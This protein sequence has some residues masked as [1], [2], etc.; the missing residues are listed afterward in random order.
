MDPI[1]PERRICG[2][3]EGGTMRRLLLALA[4]L[5]ALALVPAAV[6]DG[7]GPSPGLMYGWTGVTGPGQPRYVT[8]PTARS[9]VLAEV[10]RANG[11][12]IQFRVLKGNWGIP[13]VANDGSTG[14]LT[15]D[16]KTLVVADWVPPQNSPLRT[17][18]RFQLVH[19]RTLA[20]FKT[21]TLTGDW[22]Y[23]ALSPNGQTLYLIQHM[24]VQDTLKYQVRAYDLNGF[25]LRPRVIADRRQTGW[26]MRGYPMRRVASADGH[27]VYTLYVQP[28]G[29]PFVHALDAVNATAVCI[30]VPWKGN[31][32]IAKVRLDEAKKALTVSGPR[33][34][35]VRID[36]AT[37]RVSLPGHGGSGFP[38]ALVAGLASAAAALAVLVLI[39]LRRRNRP[40]PV[41]SPAYN[42]K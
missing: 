23:D 14:G 29:T 4:V 6:A 41:G 24:S 22:S 34:Q 31:I 37:Y 30:G 36:T 1:R 28:G 8:L 33:G 39:A 21:I 35:Q 18:S 12:V 10:D 40:Q 15:R 13:A 9:T 25:G 3:D 17:V 32:G 26:V 42:I 5:S 7:G 38:V 2:I 19:A 20:P 27:F 11:K 16:G